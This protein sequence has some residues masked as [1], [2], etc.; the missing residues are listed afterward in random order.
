MN[1]NYMVIPEAEPWEGLRLLRMP[2]LEPV[3]ESARLQLTSQIKMFPQLLET[4]AISKIKSLPLILTP[5]P[6]K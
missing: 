4:M 1:N 3:E 2:Q 5:I 6:K